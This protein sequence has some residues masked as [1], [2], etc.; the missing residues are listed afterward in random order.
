MRN[1]LP[2]RNT[3]LKLNFASFCKQRGRIPS[4][5]RNL[6]TCTTCT[7]Y[8][9]KLT[10]S[11]VMHPMLELFRTTKAAVS[12]HAVRTEVASASQGCQC[13]ACAW[14]RDRTASTLATLIH[15]GG[16]IL[17]HAPCEASPSTAFPFPCCVQGGYKTTLI[18]VSSA[19]CQPQLQ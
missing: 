2:A 7:H 17:P 10:P 18:G 15:D 3:Q 14:L 16:P 9:F 12:I 6:T 5:R 11:N 1:R 19:T 8:R 13:L 4:K